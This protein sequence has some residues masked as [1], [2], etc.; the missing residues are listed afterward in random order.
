MSVP[1]A[2]KTWAGP[3]G[4]VEDYGMQFRH[5]LGEI[6][7][8]LISNGFIISQVEDCPV[9]FQADEAFTPGHW[10]HWQLF[11]GGFAVVAEKL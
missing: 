7:N 9:Y 2:K 6:F 1:Y 5:Y 11:V 8:G 4:S 3:T 10:D